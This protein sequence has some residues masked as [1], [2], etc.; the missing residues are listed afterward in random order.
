MDVS[1][2]KSLVQEISSSARACVIYNPQ[3]VHLWTAH[4]DVSGSPIMVFVREN[5][6]EA[7][8]SQGNRL[9]VLETPSGQP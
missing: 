1:S 2:Q 9:E 3:M 7:F 5:F 4:S 8:E 6:R